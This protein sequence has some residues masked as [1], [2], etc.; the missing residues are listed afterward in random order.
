MPYPVRRI[1][2]LP[3]EMDDG[4]VLSAAVFLPDAPGEWSA[5]IDAVPY[6]KDDD[7]LAGDWDVYGFIASRGFACVRIDLRGTGSSTGILENEYLAREQDD[8]VRA[9]AL[10]AEQPWCTG[11]VG[12]TGVS[13]G[14]STPSRSRC[15][16]RPS[17]TRSCRSTSRP[18]A[19]TPTSTTSRAR[20]R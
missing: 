3:L 20:C 7:F 8:L 1:D 4:V 12:M 19:T 17:C 14:A 9:I 11:R 2:H 10:V 16:G 13:W 15:G 5:I 6:R 18:T